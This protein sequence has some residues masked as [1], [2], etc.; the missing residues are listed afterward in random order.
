VLNPKLTAQEFRRAT[1]HVGDHVGHLS[2]Q[3]AA[4]SDP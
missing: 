3:G 2:E 4:D 1:A